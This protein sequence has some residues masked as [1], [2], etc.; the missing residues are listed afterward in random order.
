MV[1][2]LIE[3]RF[4]AVLDTLVHAEPQSVEKTNIRNIRSYTL[5]NLSITHEI[6]KS[7]YDWLEVSSVF[8]EISK[9]FRKV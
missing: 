7:L 5:Y 2:C 1:M 3:K 6:S 8:L 4:P 9:A